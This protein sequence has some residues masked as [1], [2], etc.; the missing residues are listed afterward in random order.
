MEEPVLLGVDGVDRAA[1]DCPGP[2]GAQ[3]LLVICDA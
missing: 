1:V 3:W 2:S